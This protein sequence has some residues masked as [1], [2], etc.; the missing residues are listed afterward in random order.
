MDITACA[1]G[2]SGMC[3]S[4]C[5]TE[6]CVNGTVAFGGDLCDMCIA[7]SLAVP[8]ADGGAAGPCYN[9]FMGACM[10]NADCS[11]YLTCSNPCSGLP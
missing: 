6:Y 9:Q 3:Q 2:P 8:T 4:Q 1:C 5:A 7:S 11:A 10:G